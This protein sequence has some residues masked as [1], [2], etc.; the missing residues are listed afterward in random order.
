LEMARAARLM[1]AASR[2]LCSEQQQGDDDGDV[3]AN[4]EFH[5]QCIRSASY[6]QSEGDVVHYRIMLGVG[7][8]KE[9]QIDINLHTSVWQAT[10][11]KLYAFHRGGR[12][13]KSM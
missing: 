8:E 4:Q 13:S 9:R 2:P 1:S 10:V 12:R 11:K 5:L 7:K 6:A 3:N